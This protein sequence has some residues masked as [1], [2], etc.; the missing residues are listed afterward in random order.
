MRPK[1][2][3]NQHGSWNHISPIQQAI[4]VENFLR[5]RDMQ[6]FVIEQVP[7]VRAENSL[8]ICKGFLSHAVFG[9]DCA[10]QLNCLANQLEI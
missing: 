9:A 2:L 5:A 6:N 8:L 1:N 7:Q 4:R 10:S 3:A